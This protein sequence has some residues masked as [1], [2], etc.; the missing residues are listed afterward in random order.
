LGFGHFSKIFRLEQVPLDSNEGSQLGVKG[1]L[2]QVIPLDCHQWIGIS[3]NFMN[4]LL[5]DTFICSGFGSSQQQADPYTCSS[6]VIASKSYGRMISAVF[7]MEI[8]FDSMYLEI[9]Q[10]SYLVIGKSFLMENHLQFSV[11]M[12]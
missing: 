3:F 11:Y 7:E 5:S 4:Y 12:V 8:N 6:L 1:L 9:Q 2:E 10:H